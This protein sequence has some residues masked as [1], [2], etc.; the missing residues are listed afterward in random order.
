MPKSRADPQLQNALK[1]FVLSEG[2]VRSAARLLEL[3]HTMI[4]RFLQQGR[5]IPKNHKSIAL[6]LQRQ[7]IATD[8]ATKATTPGQTLSNAEL[9]LEDLAMVRR[10]CAS[11]IALIDRYDGA[12]EEIA[13]LR[14]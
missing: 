5:A 8:I 3:E 10:L 11:V 2:G 14:A 6:A 7:K 13:A 4:W 12:S 9:T 1:E